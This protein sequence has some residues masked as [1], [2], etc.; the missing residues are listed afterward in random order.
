MRRENKDKG[1]WIICNY[2]SHSF[3]VAIIF[4]ASLSS[5]IFDILKMAYL[6]NPYITFSERL[7]TI[8]RTQPL[9]SDIW[10]VDKANV[11]HC[12][13]F[14]LPFVSTGESINFAYVGSIYQIDHHNN[15]SPPL[16]L[17]LSLIFNVP[18]QFDHSRRGCFYKMPNVSKFVAWR[19]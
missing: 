17:R 9:L 4:A 15:P 3:R 18:F 2:F 5:W 7:V 19:W 14:H 11:F 13:L 8:L 6:K 10:L 12:Q 16:N 1:K